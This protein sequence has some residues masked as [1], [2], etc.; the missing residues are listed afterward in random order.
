MKNKDMKKTKRQHIKRPKEF[1]V[2]KKKN[3][4]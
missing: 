3:T 2:C 1:N 4:L